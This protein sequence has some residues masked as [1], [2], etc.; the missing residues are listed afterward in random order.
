[1][2]TLKKVLKRMMA[3][4]LALLAGMALPLLVWTAVFVAFRQL[5]AEWRSTRAGLLA[6]NLIC[7]LDTECPP[8]YQCMG[9]RCLPIVS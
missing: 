3:L 5:Y 2:M 6:G 7:S 8:G 4:G 1:M 9:G